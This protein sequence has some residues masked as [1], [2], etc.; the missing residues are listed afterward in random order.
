MRLKHSVKAY[1]FDLDGVIT[2]T[3]KIHHQA[4]KETFDCFF[5]GYLSDDDLPG[6]DLPGNKLSNNNHPKFDD[7]VDYAKHLDGKS[8][9]LGIQCLLNSRNIQLPLGQVTDKTLHSVQGIGNYKNTLFQT[10]IRQKGVSCF[11]DSIHLIR[12][13][14]NQNV[15]LALASSSKNAEFVLNYTPIKQYFHRVLDGNT[16]AALGINSKPAGDIYFECFRRLN[17]RA[18]ECVII[19]DAAAGVQAARAANPYLVVGINRLHES[20]AEVLQAHGADIVLDSLA[21]LMVDNR[22]GAYAVG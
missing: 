14:A 10:I 3:A 2:D 5:K 19:E 6:N 17:L 15:L 13:L 9:I 12:H 4:W 16:V 7:R 18:D 1:I 8:R 22:D 11:H 21:D 20:N